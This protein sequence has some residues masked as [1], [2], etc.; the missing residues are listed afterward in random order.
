M[1]ITNCILP[2]ASFNTPQLKALRKRDFAGR[3]NVNITELN[4]YFIKT[5]IIYR[6]APLDG[7]LVSTFRQNNESVDVEGYNLSIHTKPP[8]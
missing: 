2:S 4:A 8:W 5:V 7:Y 1:E 3:R 6:R